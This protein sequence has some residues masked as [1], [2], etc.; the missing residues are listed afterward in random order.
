[1]NR[2]I[3]PPD[4]SVTE[5][6]NTGT[7][8][9]LAGREETEPVKT[10]PLSRQLAEVA[11]SFKLAFAKVRTS[12]QLKL[13]DR[14]L[15][16]TQPH[17][18]RSGQLGALLDRLAPRTNRDE[19]EKYRQ[20]NQ[21]VDQGKLDLKNEQVLGEYLRRISLAHD[22]TAIANNYRFVADLIG[23]DKIDLSNREVSREYLKIA[24]SD[25]NTAA[26]ERLGVKMAI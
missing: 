2:Q 24:L 11:D 8:G 15:D 26:F 7:D 23:Q 17:G 12:R 20:L 19:P 16:N 6:N 22:N 3:N 4:R 25:D 5:A 18:S 1:M 13:I 14:T 9:W 21:M 10:A